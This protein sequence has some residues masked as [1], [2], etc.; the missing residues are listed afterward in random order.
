MGICSWCLGT[1]CSHCKS[2]RESDVAKAIADDARAE[3]TRI[4]GSSSVT[5]YARGCIDALRA[6]A[7]RIER[8]DWKRT[9]P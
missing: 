9:R 1:G 3:A 2:H 5:N 7:D 4:A 8:N 6:F